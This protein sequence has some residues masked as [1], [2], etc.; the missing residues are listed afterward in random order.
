MIRALAKIGW[1]QD[2]LT[3]PIIREDEILISFS[4]P[5]YPSCSLTM[6]I[7][8]YDSSKSALAPSSLHL[9]L[10]SLRHGILYEWRDGDIDLLVITERAKRMQDYID[11]RGTEE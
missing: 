1:E 9:M 8:L 5:A 10:S 3:D 6:S 7:Q 4:H 2:F 11:G